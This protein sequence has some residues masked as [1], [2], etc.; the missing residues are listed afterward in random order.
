MKIQFIITFAL[1]LLITQSAY[2]QMEKP[3]IIEN[4]PESYSKLIQQGFSE[5]GIRLPQYSNYSHQATSEYY[6]YTH[7]FIQ[8]RVQFKVVYNTDLQQFEIGFTN[9]KYKTTTGWEDN[10]L[11]LSKKVQEKHIEPV[12]NH[13]K[14]LI[15]AY[16]AEN[17]TEAAPKKTVVK[18]D[19]E[20]PKELAHLPLDYPF[21]GIYDDMIMVRT[22]DPK[23][24]LL[25]LHE[26]GSQI[27]FDLS[28]DERNINFAVFQADSAA[29]PFIIY[30]DENNNPKGA[31]VDGY[32]MVFS[33]IVGDKMDISVRTPD[34]EILTKSGIDFESSKTHFNEIKLG[35]PTSN[36]P[37]A[38]IVY[39]V[40][41]Q[42]FGDLLKSSSTVIGLVGCGITA[43]SAGTSSIVTAIPCASAIVSVLQMGLPK[44]NILNSKEV[45]FA[46]DLLALASSGTSIASTFKHA[47]K[48]SEIGSML[49]DGLGMISSTVGEYHKLGAK[50]EQSITELQQ[51]R[52]V[53]L[54]ILGAKYI[55]E[56]TTKEK[57][58]R[59][60]G[61]DEGD[62]DYVWRLIGL[63]KQFKLR[64]DPKNPAV[65]GITLLK[66]AQV[67]EKDTLAVTK[68]VDGFTR[69]DY[70]VIMVS[71][72]KFELHDFSDLVSDG[73]SNKFSASIRIPIIVNYRLNGTDVLGRT[74]NRSN[75]AQEEELYITI[76][77]KDVKTNGTTFWG[78]SRSD[79]S[80][81]YSDAVTFKGE[82]SEDKQFIKSI[83]I[84]KLFEVGKGTNFE[85]KT[86]SVTLKDLPAKKS[87]A[88][89]KNYKTY[90]FKSKATPDYMLPTYTPAAANTYSS[91][92]QC[93]FSYIKST[94][95][96]NF[97]DIEQRTFVR[98]NTDKITHITLSGKITFGSMYDK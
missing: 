32:T 67:G 26:D 33:N 88:R 57:L 91:V 43:F 89:Y 39:Y 65:A 9:R 95:L 20:L 92:S 59:A 29:P 97:H 85:K 71:E 66:D 64:V 69:T 27:G 49:L 87:N 60:V 35:S 56:G 37:S 28:D 55:E 18:K 7:T 50:Y 22:G 83:T 86:I 14:E 51:I 62:N 93:S 73:S 46:N 42:K 72:K 13:I 19:I 17:T 8:H 76:N 38:D 96:T 54:S 30:F 78:E 24:E 12:V 15:A 68:L 2:G 45:T 34:N 40:E 74:N 77:I 16:E 94:D 75:P 80:M 79:P 98:I 3:Y 36:G 90:E 63:D 84:K 58:Y 10:V 82:L 23:L 21:K 70:H 61:G 53:D 48:L 1:G 5:K 52:K 6:T 41:D 25:C 31:V 44:D 11:P 4:V 81:S 47:S